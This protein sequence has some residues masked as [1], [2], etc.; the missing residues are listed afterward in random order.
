MGWKQVGLAAI[1]EGHFNVQLDKRWQR[2]NWG[3]RPLEKA[4]LSYARLDSHYLLALRQMQMQ[5]LEAR[6]LVEQAQ[7][8]FEQVAAA[9]P[10]LRETR[11]DDFWH[12]KGTLDLPPRSQAILRELYVMRDRE[13]QRRDWPPFK[14]MG[15]KTLVDSLAAAREA[16]DGAVKAGKEF[17]ASLDEMT[18]AAKTGMESTKDMVAK[19]GR[20]SRLGERSRGTIDAGSASCYLILKSM[21]ESIKKYL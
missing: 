16:F 1:L 6:D 4:A 11:P 17:G 15:D 7:E 10:A 14:I 19:K 20:S 3:S 13:A 5:A 18:A 9:Q 21:G 8:T 12:I 2:H